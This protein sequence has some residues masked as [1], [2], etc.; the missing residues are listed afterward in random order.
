LQV[1]RA[2]DGEVFIDLSGKR[3]TLLSSDL[4]IADDAKICALAGII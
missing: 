1:R 2:L 3:H 4:V